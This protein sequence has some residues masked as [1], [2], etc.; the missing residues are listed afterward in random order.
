MPT[1]ADPYGGVVLA[2]FRS[3]WGL[4]AFPNWDFGHGR[5]WCDCNPPPSPT[6]GNNLLEC[7]LYP[8]S[9]V[10]KVLAVVTKSDRER[11]FKSKEA[12]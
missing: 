5:N 8:F 11:R 6:A 12:F 4:S 3:K 1:G 10:V 2:S 7:L 9:L